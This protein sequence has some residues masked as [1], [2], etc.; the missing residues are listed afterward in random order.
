MKKKGSKS[1]FAGQRNS[2]L[3]AAFR[4]IAAMRHVTTTDEIFRRVAASPASRFWVS[5]QR[6]AEVIGRMLK[7]DRLDTMR[8]KRREMFLKILELVLE[9][10]R[11]HPV[12]TISSAA[13]YAVNSP[14]P[15]FYITPESARVIFCRSRRNRR[16]L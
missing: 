7:G 10:R 14:A 9:Y 1:E 5:E 3:E 15:E 4:R 8:P 6:A 12:A 2:E 11:A 16:S 13:W